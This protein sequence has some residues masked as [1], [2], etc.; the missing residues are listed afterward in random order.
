MRKNSHLRVLSLYSPQ[1]LLLEK[2]RKGRPAFLRD[3]LILPNNYGIIYYKSG[4]RQFSPQIIPRLRNRAKVCQLNF[5]VS[6]LHYALQDK[7]KMLHCISKILLRF[8]N[9]S[10]TFKAEDLKQKNNLAP[11]VKTNLTEKTHSDSHFKQILF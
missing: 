2:E 10:Q 7:I 11:F 1:I 4:I 3:P 6:P 9:N 8:R 5:L